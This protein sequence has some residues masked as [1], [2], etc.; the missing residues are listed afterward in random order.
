MSIE[1]YN[2][3]LRAVDITML[4]LMIILFI[5]N[6]KRDQNVQIGIFYL[7]SLIL[8]LLVNWKIV[9]DTIWFVILEIGD[10]SIPILFWYFCKSIFDDDFKLGKKYLLLYVINLFVLY[11]LFY[12]T[13]FGKLNSSAWYFLI[14]KHT[15][16]V[17]SLV[18]VI[19]GIGE[20]FRNKSVDLLESRIKLRARFILVAGFLNV[21]TLI[22]TIS[23]N[24]SGNDDYFMLFQIIA[25]GIILFMIFYYLVEFKSGFFFKKANIKTV[26]IKADSKISEGLNHLIRIDK[27]YLQ[28]G[29]TIRKLSDQMNE[30][31]Y[32]VRKYINQHLGF[33]NFNDFL[34]SYRI[35]NACELL[36]DEKKSDLTVLEI[37]YSLG[38]NSLGPFNKAFKNHTGVTPTTYRKQE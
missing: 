7:L 6:W 23:G 16:H 21:L 22:I 1:Y 5:K 31:E 13:Q 9:D 18:Y 11:V 24:F 3:L 25:I 35:Q 4:T 26:V 17:I 12:F 36:L 14:I 29:L 30:Q 10:L 28:E 19:L 15:S 34:N 37:A 20:A 2:D 8:F 33:R 38:Y 32:K 27:I